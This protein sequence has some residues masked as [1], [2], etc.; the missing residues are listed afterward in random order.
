MMNAFFSITHF[1]CAVCFVQDLAN[2]CYICDI[3]RNDFESEKLDFQH[4]LQN[5][6]NMWKYLWFLIYLDEKNSEDYN[7]IEQYVADC[8]ATDN[9]LLWLPRKKAMVLV[10]PRDRY[11][12][13][14]IY[15]KIT[16][17]KEQLGA[18]EE[19]VLL[20]TRERGGAA[21]AES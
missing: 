10:K 2:K 12:L 9:S 19:S 5:D 17:L 13:F 6:H 21:S 7:G 14:T 18:L 4:H 11:D 8:V 1:V 16:A 15:S 3:D 20:S